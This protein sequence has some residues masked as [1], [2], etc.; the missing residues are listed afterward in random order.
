MRALLTA[1]ALGAAAIGAVVLAAALAA[2]ALADAAG[3]DALRVAV[4]PIELLAFERTARSSSTTFGPG[5][6]LLAL[7]GGL[8]NAAGAAVLLAR[9]R[10]VS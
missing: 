4:G 5:L 10:R 2:A 1:F 8:L 3:R 9:A 6:W 7:A